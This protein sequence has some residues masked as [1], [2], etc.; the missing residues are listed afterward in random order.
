MAQSTKI[1]CCTGM[2]ITFKGG[3]LA[4]IT[5]FMYPLTLL[6]AAHARLLVVIS[7]A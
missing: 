7:V 3:G 2:Q 4:N 6:T 1:T 5:I